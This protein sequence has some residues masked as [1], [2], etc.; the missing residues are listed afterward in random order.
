MRCATLKTCVMFGI[1]P[2]NKNTYVYNTSSLAHKLMNIF[3]CSMELT[4]VQLD[5]N[6]S[7]LKDIDERTQAY[8]RWC[9]KGDNGSKFDETLS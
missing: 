5:V 9:C 7:A 3:N 1:V 4:T 6:P 8:K 2:N